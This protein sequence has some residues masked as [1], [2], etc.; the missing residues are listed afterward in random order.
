MEHYN[1]Q[2]TAGEVVK[3]LTSEI[4][5]KVIL[6]TGVS[7]GGLG[8]FFNQYIALAKPALLILAGRNPAKNQETAESLVK[9][10]PDVTVRTLQLD[11]ESLKQVREAAAIVNGWSDVPHID[12]LVNNAGIMACDYAKTEDG[13][14]RQFATSHIGPFLFTNLVVSKILTSKS[15]RIVNVSSDGHRLSQIRWPDIGFT[16]G[17]LYNKWRAYGQG[18]T[19]NILLSVALA[20]KLG[21]KGLTAVSLHPGVIGTNLGN[22]ID[23]NTEHVFPFSPDITK[24]LPQALDDA[25]IQPENNGQYLQDCHIADPYID[26]IKPYAYNKIEADKLWKLSEKLVG[27]SFDY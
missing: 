3:N 8:A 6:T 16:D 2:T 11:L 26:T 24:A 5:G 22:H 4:A 9:E 15:P 21:K 14:E 27:Q 17:Q 10:F 23:W 13:F 12:V 1:T 7:P 18:K 25:D 19:A 20:M